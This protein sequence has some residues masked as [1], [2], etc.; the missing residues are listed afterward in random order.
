MATRTPLEQ[1]EVVVK[2]DRRAT[3]NL[4]MEVR[5]KAREMGLEISR[6][7]IVRHSSVKPKSARHKSSRK[8]R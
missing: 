3:E 2:G 1:L 6:V 8:R 4:I 7:E 5:E